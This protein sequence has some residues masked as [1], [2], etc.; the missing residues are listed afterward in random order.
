MAAFEKGSG[1]TGADGASAYEIAVAGGFVGT[2]AQWLTSL[3][4]A[5]GDPGADSIVPGPQGAQ[6][7]PGADSI[8][9]G[10]NGDVGPQGDPGAAAT[11]AVGSVDP[12]AAGSPPTITNSGTAS[13]AIFDFEIPA[14]ATGAQGIQGEPGAD[15]TGAA[16]YG[17]IYVAGGVAVQT[18]GLTFAKI[19]QFDT[20]RSSVGMT[21]DPSADTI[22]VASA[23]VYSLNVS[24]SF[25]GSSGSLV[26]VALFLDGVE[27]TGAG[28]VRKIGTGGDVGA[29]GFAGQLITAGPNVVAE[30]R[31]KT[32]GA[33]DDFS[34]ANGVFS[35]HSIGSDGAAGADGSAAS[36]ALGT[37]ATGAAGS[38]VIITDSGTPD[39]AVFNFTIPRGDDGAQ[40]IQGVAGSSAAALGVAAGDETTEAT[41]G[42]G[43]VSFRMPYAFNL[44]ELR[45]T[46]VNAPTGSPF[47][48]DIFDDGASVFGVTKLQIDT[49][50]ESSVSSSTPPTFTPQLV[51]DDSEITVDFVSVGGTFGGAGIKVWLIGTIA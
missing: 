37:V 50:F 39:A 46:A 42:T 20:A 25:Y 48:V 44:D 14:G 45:V 2:E 8:V 51:A 4:G 41:A 32:D 9:P 34:V 12:I 26:S 15:A 5:Q 31:V 19:T 40:G 38:S 27:Q 33:S 13:A 35:I 30:L 17:E 23:G 24:L 3:E 7:D 1:G 43:K 29:A 6:G 36:V 18:P 28:F 47:V 10:P 49:G 16:T 21:S 22:T 11:I